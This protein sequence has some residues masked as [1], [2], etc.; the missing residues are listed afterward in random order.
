[1]ILFPCKGAEITRTAAQQTNLINYANAGGRIFA[2]HFSYVWLFNDAPFNGTASWSINQCDSHTVP[3]G[4]S[5]TTANG[6]PPDQTGYIN[7]TFPKGL[8]LA[9]WLQNIGASTTLGQIPL[10]V[11]RWDTKKPGA[12]APSQEWMQIQD[13]HIGNVLMHYTFNTPV[14]TP[15]ASQCGRVLFDDFHVEN[16]GFINADSAYNMTFPAECACFPDK[17]TASRTSSAAA[18]GATSTRTSATYETCLAPAGGCLEIGKACTSNAQCCGGVLHG[19][20]VRR[21][22]DPAGEAPRVHD[23]RPRAPA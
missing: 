15:A 18:T 21:P 12:V 11:L 20:R 7:T 22:D 23:L 13:A 16:H 6:Y 3:T 10:N 9:Q 17:A 8:A 14:G 19:R 1:M 4:Y 5:C 2:T